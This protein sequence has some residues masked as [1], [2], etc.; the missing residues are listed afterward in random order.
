MVLQIRKGIG[1]D[2][3]LKLRHGQSRIHPL[4]KQGMRRVSLLLRARFGIRI[5][6]TALPLEGIRRQGRLPWLVRFAEGFPIDA[7]AANV[8]HGQAFEH[9]LKTT[10]IRFE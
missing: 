6:P 7:G 1:S 9:A 3:A 10:A 4:P 2:V 8:Q 5:F